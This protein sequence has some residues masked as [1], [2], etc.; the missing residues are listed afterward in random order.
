MLLRTVASAGGSEVYETTVPETET[1]DLT[2]ALRRGYFVF[3]E[4]NGQTHNC[5]ESL[6]TSHFRLRHLLSSLTSRSALGY[7]PT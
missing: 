6:I 4:V 1:E 5:P 2:R 3:V 7:E